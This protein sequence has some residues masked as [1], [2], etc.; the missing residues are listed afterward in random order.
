MTLVR[1]LLISLLLVAAFALLSAAAGVLVFCSASTLIPPAFWSDGQCGA[2]DK[3]A[4]VFGI[5]LHLG[6]LVGLVIYTASAVV[7]FAVRRWRNAP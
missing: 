6:A 3:P 1:T 2:S 4:E 7:R 5:Y